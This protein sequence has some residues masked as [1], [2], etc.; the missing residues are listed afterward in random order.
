MSQNPTL[1]DDE[2]DLRE[3]FAILWSHKLLITLFTGLSIFLA[4][5]YVITAEKKFTATSVFQIEQSDGGSS[6]N[7]S[8]ELGALARLLRALARP[9]LARA[10]TALQLLVAAAQLVE[11][12][13]PHY[14]ELLRRGGKRSSELLA[15]SASPRLRRCDESPRRAA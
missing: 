9:V 15:S 7:F 3:L 4:G 5:Y 12:V 6:F 13:L 2:I 1:E 11:L 8:G 10:K 14:Q